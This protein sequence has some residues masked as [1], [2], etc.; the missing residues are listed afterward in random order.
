MVERFTRDITVYL[1]GGS[2]ASVRESEI[3]ITTFMALRNAQP[4]RYVWSAKGAEILR[5][6]SGLVRRLKSCRKGELFQEQ[7]TR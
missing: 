2:F 7:Y 6:S 3:S 5:K 1:R 4:H